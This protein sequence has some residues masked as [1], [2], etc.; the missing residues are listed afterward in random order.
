M[1]DTAFSNVKK[2]AEEPTNAPE[3]LDTQIRV[4]SDRENYFDKEQ[5]NEACET[6]EASLAFLLL[7][8]PL[9]HYTNYSEPY[10]DAEP[11]IP[12]LKQRWQEERDTTINETFRALDKQAF[13]N[14]VRTPYEM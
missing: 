4:Y 2:H 1:V 3:D 5:N 13:W 8:E 11:A 7:P 10:L 9:R 12:E 6:F 14:L